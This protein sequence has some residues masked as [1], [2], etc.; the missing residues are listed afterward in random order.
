MTRGS[1]SPV[2]ASPRLSFSVSP[3]L[4]VVTLG[5]VLEMMANVADEFVDFLAAEFIVERGHL[6]LAA[7]DGLLQLVVCMFDRVIRLQR[8]N[9][10]LLV[11]D[12][13]KSAFTLWTMTAV[14]VLLV[15]RL[16]CG[17]RISRPCRRRRGW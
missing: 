6:F 9:F 5:L 12:F 13:H 11:V 4:R 1:P 10:N 8:C 14:A 17:E 3:C 2:A 7:G 15:V 16:G